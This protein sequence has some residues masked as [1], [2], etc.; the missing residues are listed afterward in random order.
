MLYIKLSFFP[1]QKLGHSAKER[2]RE[3]DKETG[4]HEGSAETPVVFNQK[5]SMSAL[6]GFEILFSQKASLFDQPFHLLFFLYK[7][8]E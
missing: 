2:E 7:F 6:K 3:R 1:Q 4:S 5:L 8:A